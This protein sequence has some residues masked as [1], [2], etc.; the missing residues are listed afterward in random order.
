MRI[1]RART[2]AAYQSVTG[3]SYSSMSK[4]GQQF[5]FGELTSP[6][7]SMAWNADDY[8]GVVK[9]SRVPFILRSLVETDIARM[10]TQTS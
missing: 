1:C 10:K 2:A 4:E 6:R 7:Q 8:R 3:I 5:K 9:P